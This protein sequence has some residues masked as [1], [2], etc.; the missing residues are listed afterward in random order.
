M[1][2]SKMEDIFHD[3]DLS[4]LS[5]NE[6]VLLEAADKKV[7]LLE[8]IKFLS[9][10]SSNLDEFYRVRMPVLLALAKLSKKEKNNIALP[11]GLLE[12]ANQT[13]HRQ[14]QTYGEILSK[15]IIPELHSH[16]IDFVYGKDIPVFL[17]EEITGYFLSQVLAFL[18]PVMLDENDT[19]FFP[20]NNE[21]YFLI[22]LNEKENEKNSCAQYTIQ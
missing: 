9:I 22:T 1:L 16:L 10:Y 18:Q 20:N 17:T 15:S 11:E 7:P 19:N 3:R 5:F 8:R 12:T 4:W 6:R 21:L 13:V 14:Q 2:D